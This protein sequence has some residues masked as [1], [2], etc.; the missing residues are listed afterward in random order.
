MEI[1]DEIIQGS[2]DDYVREY[3]GLDKLLQA[4]DPWMAKNG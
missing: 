1:I 3:P 4:K 2:L